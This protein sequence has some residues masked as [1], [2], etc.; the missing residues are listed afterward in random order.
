MML[1]TFSTQVTSIVATITGN[2]PAVFAMVGTLWVIH[3]FNW[4]VGYKLSQYG[5]VPRTWRGLP[6]IFSSPFLHANF[7]H[8]FFNSIPLLILA[9]L[10]LLY[11]WP[12]FIYVTVV[13]AVLGGFGTWLLA[14]LTINLLG[15]L[16]YWRVCVF[17][18]SV[19]S[20]LTCFRAHR[21]L[22]GKDI[23]LVC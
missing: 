22:P 19:V 20:Y 5:I 7:N 16:W 1:D 6:G 17:I 13:V 11:G 18:I 2:L 9:S 12:I 14:R 8:L 21:N 10:L 4:F 15:F 3:L 23:Y